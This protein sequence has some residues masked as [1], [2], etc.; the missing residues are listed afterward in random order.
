MASALEPLAVSGLQAHRT[1]TNV[2]AMHR[3]ARPGM[4]SLNMAGTYWPTS[5]FFLVSVRFDESVTERC[6]RVVCAALQTVIGWVKAL[7]RRLQPAAAEATAPSPPGAALTR[8]QLQ[9]LASTGARLN[10]SLTV[11]AAATETIRSGP[12]ADASALAGEILEEALTY[13]PELAVAAPPTT[14]M[15]WIV[16]LCA[17]IKYMP[18]KLR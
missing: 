8:E 18:M 7:F 5:V 10:N 15:F 1:Q 12:G 11:I 2:S 3:V 4:F 9:R 6:R 17:L 13:H 14:S 16:L